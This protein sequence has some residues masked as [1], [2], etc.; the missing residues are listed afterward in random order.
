MISNKVQR[1]FDELF[2]R[3]TL[4]ANVISAKSLNFSA[5]ARSISACPVKA[6]L[7][8][9]DRGPVV[10]SFN[11]ENGLNFDALESET[12]RRLSL[13]SGKKYAK[14]LQGF[15]IRHLP[16]LGRLYQMPMV[17]D[18]ELLDQERYLLEFDG[19]ESFIEVDKQGFQQLIKGAQKKCFT[20][21]VAASAKYRSTQEQGKQEAVGQVAQIKQQEATKM[22]EKKSSLLSLDEVNERFKNGVDLPVI[23]SVADQ[24]ISMKS[25]DN[26]E[27]VDLVHLIESDPVVSAK[28]IS[29]ANS[30]FF[31]YEGS[32]ETVQE[33]VYHVLGVDIS[34]NISLAL[35][36]GQ[37]FNGPMKGDLGATSIWRH[38]VYCSVL[39]QSIATKI[40]GQAGI[41]PGTAYLFGL[42][43]NIGY[44]ALGH[45]YKVQF[46]AFNKMVTLK[47]DISVEKLEKSLLG[48]THTNVGSLL[49]KS[50][51][52]PPQYAV[53]MENHHNPSYHGDYQEYVNIVYM[54][55]LL[56]KSV[57][58]G[59]AEE[60]QIPRV[61]LERYN[62]DESELVSMLDI[63]MGWHENLDHLAHQLAA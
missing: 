37:Q 24:L 17:V 25:E 60:G 39:S 23:P 33:A 48:V 14:E 5:Y 38:A 61:L 20:K 46:T 27:L 22:S 41:K 29:Y 36:L 11:A 9:D 28:I 45:I 54:S 55:N 1:F 10:V 63:V 47:K 62:L 50:W 7:F 43:H 21:S 30:P 35:S 19:K 52:M 59:D 42:L 13:D 34:L 49:M 44:L 18:V 2:I 32:L 12:G 3:Y 31:S 6:V 26:F 58:I 15:S 56:L 57:G 53:L 51:G 4:H 40:S 16:S 8:A